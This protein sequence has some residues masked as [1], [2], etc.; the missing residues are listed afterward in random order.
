M[1]YRGFEIKVRGDIRF[2][3]LSKGRTLSGKNIIELKSKIDELFDFN[4]TQQEQEQPKGKSR[5]WK[6]Q[7]KY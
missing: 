7:L 6:D 5:F 3:N 1:F 2:I 4:S